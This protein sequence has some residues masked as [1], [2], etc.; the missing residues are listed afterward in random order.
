M[1]KFIILLSLVLGIGTMVGYGQNSD[2]LIMSA[3][4][5]IDLE[6]EE[7]DIV[8]ELKN[9]V[10]KI[11]SLVVFIN[12]STNKFSFV[13]EYRDEK[14]FIN[15]EAD[16][17]QT[18][19]SISNF[20]YLYNGIE[21]EKYSDVRSVTFIPSIRVANFLGWSEPSIS[22]M[23]DEGMITDGIILNLKDYEFV[24]FSNNPD[25]KP[26]DILS[27]DPTGIS[28]VTATTDQVYYAN[29]VLNIESAETIGLATVYNLTGSVVGNYT[30]ETNTL[31]ADAGL[32][33]GVYLVKYGTNSAKIVVQ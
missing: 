21:F 8:W 31:S 24:V 9:N 13:V 32:Q 15:T 10:Y 16:M 20:V 6:T 25:L 3:I 12:N 14:H 19:M 18:A 23:M 7:G 4:S 22:V 2:R 28:D 30:S 1:K 11:D 33:K 26:E 5:S 27:K 17:L 29:G